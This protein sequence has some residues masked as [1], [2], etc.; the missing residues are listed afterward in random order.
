MRRRRTVQSERNE[1]TVV[2]CA[3][4]ALEADIR[5]LSNQRNLSEG[6]KAQLEALRVELTAVQKAKQEC[7]QGGLLYRPLQILLMR[8]PRERCRGSS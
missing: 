8:A 3:L 4:V 2:V 5:K 6:D 7:E 1:L